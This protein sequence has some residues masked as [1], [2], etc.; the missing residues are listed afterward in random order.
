[1]TLFDSLQREFCPPLD[2]SLLAALLAD[3]ESDAHGNALVPTPRQ[4]DDLKATLRELSSQADSDESQ[5]L[6][7]FSDLRNLS[8]TED[9]SSTPEFYHGNTATSSSLH[10]SDDSSES[11]STQQH[12]FSS[13]LGFL[14][15]ALPHVSTETLSAALDHAHAGGGNGNADDMDMWDIIAGIL[16]AESIREME[17]RGLD[18][19]D[20]EE[21]G[22]ILPDDEIGWE[23]VERK[24]NHGSSKPKAGKRKGLRGKTITL[25]DVRQQQ[26]FRA[27]PKRSN[28]NINPA[29]PPRGLAAPDPWTQLSSLA[30]HLATLLPPHPPSFFQS[31]FHAPEHPTP[32][33]ALHACLKA[34]CASLP[35]PQEQEEEEEEEE[36]ERSYTETLLTLLD[37]LLPEYES[38]FDDDAEAHARL[39]ADAEVALRATRGRGDDA[40]DLVKLLRE[41]DFDADGQVA[42]GVYHHLAPDARP[43][44][45]QTQALPNGPPPVQPPPQLRPPKPRPPPA[46]SLS[47]PSPSPSPFQ[48][49]SVPPRRTSG[50]GAHHPL[51][52]YIPAYNNR[53]TNGN[54]KTKTKTVRGAGNALG[55]GGKGDV[56]ELG[57]VGIGERR[58]RIG[59]SVRRRNEL[60]RQATRMWQ[61]GNRRTRGG[62]VAWYFAE[63]AREFQELARK[64]ALNAARVMVESKRLASKKQSEVDL[65]GTTVSEAIVIVKEILQA[66]CPSPSK[67]LKIITGRGSHSVNRVSVLKP[68]IKKALVEDGWVVGSWEGG[69]VVSGKR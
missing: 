56:G 47:K 34:I 6:S 2:S 10:S 42:M 38:S 27:L 16:T 50:N 13:P 37:I 29:S 25:V 15:A 53:P 23:T 60:L 45:T 3:L 9:T 35:P 36:E 20:E 30:T 66:Q 52:A 62:E 59:E 68:A 31:Y 12:P 49:Q 58:R 24:K 55:Q 19:L 14:Q 33:L 4:I 46:P 69:L 5:Q 8:L 40:L 21:L 57:D 63:R 22:G 1:M 44:H 51:A 54:G 7:E 39:I 11:C 32:Y 61:A 26:H 48:W 65:H 43:K 41:L 17:E 18:G 64:E 28:A 67:P